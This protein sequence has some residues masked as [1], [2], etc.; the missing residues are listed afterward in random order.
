MCHRARALTKEKGSSSISTE[1]P[2]KWIGWP[3]YL[4]NVAVP[5]EFELIF[6]LCEFCNFSFIPRYWPIS[7]FI[8]YASTWVL[9]SILL[10]IYWPHSIYITY[11]CWYKSCDKYTTLICKWIR[12]KVWQ[13]HVSLLSKLGL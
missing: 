13:K 5:L 8:C 7:I 4:F 2:Y 9:Y 3:I 6:H 1:S 11:T 12:L 10:K